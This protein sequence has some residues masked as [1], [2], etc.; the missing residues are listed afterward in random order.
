MPRKSN[1]DVDLCV[2]HM[3]KLIRFAEERIRAIPELGVSWMK[4]N[5]FANAVVYVVCLL[6]LALSMKSDCCC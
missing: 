3:G 1:Y 2:D 5:G 4:V 6:V